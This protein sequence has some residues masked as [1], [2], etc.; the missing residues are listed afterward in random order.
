MSTVKPEIP[1]SA[2]EVDDMYSGGA[3]ETLASEVAPGAQEQDANVPPEVV[4][5][6]K[7]PSAEGESQS[8][9]ASGAA[10]VEQKPATAPAAQLSA[11][12]IKQIA[13]DTAAEFERARQSNQPPPS[14]SPEE[15]DRLLNPVKV[16]PEE[17]AEAFGITEAT[18]QQIKAIEKLLA[19]S[20]KHSTSL[21]TLM[22]EERAR[23]I[24]SE[25]SPIQQQFEQ[26]QRVEARN[27]LI[28]K[29]PYLDKYDELVKV[30]ANQISPVHAN[31]RDKTRDEIFDEVA[32]FVKNTLAKSG[33]NLS[34]SQIANP[35]PAQNAVPQMAAR[36]QPGRSVGSQ[37]S[38]KPNDPD[39][40]IYS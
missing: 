23:K 6:V 11:E 16:T 37:A 20:V 1:A 7:E 31:G 36:S 5:P 12:Q 10:E 13:V 14:L 15:I 28:A 21:A 30:A 27:A 22:L 32:G 39:D 8:S 26:Y 9:E 24:Q 33:V 17:V 34:A 38:G 19:K 29:H 18:P 40:D 3:E 25:M 2:E 4:E 35:V